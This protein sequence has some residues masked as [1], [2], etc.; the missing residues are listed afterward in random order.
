MKTWVWKRVDMKTCRN[1]N[2]WTWKRVDLK[3]SENENVWRWTR[4][5]MKP[6]EMKTRGNE[7]MWRWTHRDVALS[8]SLVIY[9]SFH[10]L[11]VSVVS[12]STLFYRFHYFS[13]FACFL[14]AFGFLHVILWT[15]MQ[16][17]CTWGA[18]GIQLK[19]NW[20]SIEIQFK[21]NSLCFR[22]RCFLI[23]IVLLFPL[24]S[25]RSR[26]TRN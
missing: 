11:L 10:C 23:S 16:L 22:F 5:E 13:I 6:C 17:G 4:V 26:C 21:F 25:R 8:F 18:I 12:S 24:V 3:T 19:F 2:M 1:E 15:C 7:N 20:N 9:F 14:S